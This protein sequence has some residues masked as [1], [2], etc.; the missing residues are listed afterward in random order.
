[1]EVTAA[2]LGRCMREKSGPLLGQKGRKGV[3]PVRWALRVE[4]GAGYGQR[5]GGLLLDTMPCKRTRGAV[6]LAREN[7]EEKGRGR[8]FCSK[9]R[10]HFPFLFLFKSNSNMNQIKF[11]HSLKYIFL[12]K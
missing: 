1:M 8:A 7:P 5:R 12:F 10:E 9:E 3:G 6:G 11:E 2:A 4:V